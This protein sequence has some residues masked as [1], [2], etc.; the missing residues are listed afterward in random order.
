MVTKI[1]QFKSSFVGEQDDEPVAH[2]LRFEEHPHLTGLIPSEYLDNVSLGPSLPD[3]LLLG[4][5][6]DGRLRV[7]SPIKVKLM[8][9]GEH[10]VAEAVEFNEFGFG[11]NL[12]EALID[13]QRAIAEL[14]FTLE[15][16][17][18]RL[19]TDLRNV[20][21]ADEALGADA[22]LSGLQLSRKNRLKVGAY[23]SHRAGCE[24]ETS[25]S[26]SSH[27]QKDNHSDAPVG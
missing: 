27:F 19:G 21:A 1:P 5:L 24:T 3:E 14:H 2:D 6:R 17:Q 12:S 18:D 25:F 4:F 9:E 15:Q 7:R 10:V 11:K 26:C 13:L 16:D 23:T 20:R 22:T 8:T